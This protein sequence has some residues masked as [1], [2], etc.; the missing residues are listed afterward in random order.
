M[1][2]YKTNDPVRTAENA[3]TP[4]DEQSTRLD[5]QWLPA[6]AATPTVPAN[7]QGARLADDEVAKPDVYP[8]QSRALV[9]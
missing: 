5:N 6:H 2:D 8:E 4:A 3:A 7:S 1:S 9:V